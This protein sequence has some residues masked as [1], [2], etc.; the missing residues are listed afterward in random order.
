MYQFN[1]EEQKTK[2]SPMQLAQVQYLALSS[3]PK[4]LSR[5]SFQAQYLA[6]QQL[7][8]TIRRVRRGL[9]RR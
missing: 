3:E 1:F 6:K 5:A 8:R 9:P 7:L 4:D 2:K